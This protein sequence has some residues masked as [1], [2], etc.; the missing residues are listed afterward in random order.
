MVCLPLALGIQILVVYRSSRPP[1][2]F[3]SYY[4]R[5]A[6]VSGGA[7]GYWGEDAPNKI[8][9]SIKKK[10]L[11]YFSTRGWLD[12]TECQTLLGYFMPKTLCFIY[13]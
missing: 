11:K 1:V 13:A 3:C 2:F 9:D 8:P 6:P 10:S 7:N 5:A 12:F 4:H